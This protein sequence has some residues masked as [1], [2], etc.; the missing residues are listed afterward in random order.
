MARI[1]SVQTEPIY[2]DVRDR[3]LNPYS[4]D[5]DAAQVIERVRRPNVEKQCERLRQA[6]ENRADLVVLTEGSEVMG[7][8]CQASDRPEARKQV[9][10]EIPGETTEAYGAIARQ[11]SMHVVAG[12]H[13]RVGDTYYNAAVLIGRDG[14]IIGK[15]HKV[16]LTQAERAGITCG[17]DYPVFDTDIG[18]VGILICYDWIYPE[19]LASLAC[20][21]PDLVCFPTHGYGWTE[22]LGEVT[23]KCRAADHSVNV[24]MA[25]TPS[26]F[27]P[28]RSC[29]VNRAGQI[30]ADAGYHR[31]CIIYADLDLR[32]QRYDKFFVD[33]SI[34]DLG[35]RLFVDRRPETYKI[36]TM[37]QP[38]ALEKHMAQEHVRRR[39]EPKER[40]ARAHAGWA[41][42]AENDR[43]M[44]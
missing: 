7:N 2:Y 1:A 23:A 11:Y 41:Y 35:G 13:E 25:M 37:E 9:V 4:P 17:S 5:F 15:Y 42:D 14:Q 34:S 29:I 6:G 27:G 39:H 30:V 19:S 44:E 10:C 21:G 36:L 18:R 38:P 22:D 16:H 26:K 24:A 20:N 3:A 33:E 31:D 32:L 43:I 8:W 12:L 40:L 28:G